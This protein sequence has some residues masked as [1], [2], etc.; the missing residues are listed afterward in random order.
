MDSINP[1]F[2][3]FFFLKGFKVS[4]VKSFLKT[5]IRRVERCIETHDTWRARAAENHD[6][7]L[8]RNFFVQNSISTY[9]SLFLSFFT[10]G[11]ARVE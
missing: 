3:F 9:V 11:F 4:F 5:S 1:I 8:K 10:R 6:G 2:F 7:T